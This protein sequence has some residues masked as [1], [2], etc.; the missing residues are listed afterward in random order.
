MLIG[1]QNIYALGDRI[2][3]HAAATADRIVARVQ[4]GVEHGAAGQSAQEFLTSRVDPDVEEHLQQLLVGTKQLED[5]A[6][7]HPDQV[8][9][10][11]YLLQNKSSRAITTTTAVVLAL[12]LPRRRR[13]SGGDPTSSGPPHMTPENWPVMKPLLAPPPPACWQSLRLGSTSGRESG[14]DAGPSRGRPGSR[15]GLQDV[16]TLPTL[17]FDPRQR[18]DRPDKGAQSGAPQRRSSR[19]TGRPGPARP[20]PARPADPSIGPHR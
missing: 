9:A 3:P 19:P 18:G 2:E 10:Q 12:L 1:S 7:H 15:Q 14:A 5:G 20:G 6:D 11:G 16:K 13:R 4:G 8:V 17:G